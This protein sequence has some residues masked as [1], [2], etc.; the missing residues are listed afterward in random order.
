MPLTTGEAKEMET[1]DKKEEDHLLEETDPHW[2]MEAH[3]H[4]SIVEKK[5]TMHATT[6][7]RNSNY[8][9]RGTINRPTL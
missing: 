4:A 2:D 1:G 9:M 6:L 5:G 7:R 8:A 3:L